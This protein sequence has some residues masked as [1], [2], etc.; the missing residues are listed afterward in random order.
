MTEGERQEIVDGGHLQ[1]L[2]VCYY[3]YAACNAFFSLFG[4]LY[5]FMGVLIGGVIAAA[6]VPP[7]KPPLPPPAYFAAIFG[8]IGAAIFLFLMGSAILMV[9][10]AGRL[11][12]RRSRVFCLVVGALSCIWFPFGTALGVFTIVVLSRSSVP[13]LFGEDQPAAIPGAASSGEA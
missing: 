8:V 9:M 10:A 5:V 13:R 6:P 2:S 7:D 4:L 1:V 11:R 3:I 12:R